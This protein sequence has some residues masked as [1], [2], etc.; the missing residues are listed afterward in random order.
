M[1]LVG[2]LWPVFFPVLGAII[3]L[4]HIRWKH[5]RGMNALETFLVWQLALSI[6]LNYLYSGIGHLVFPDQVAASIGWPPGSPFQREV[7]MWDFAIGIV[8]LLCLKF[9]STGFWIATVIA[10][11]IF[12]LG[13]G[14]GHVYELFVHGDV[15]VNNAGPVMFMDLLYPVFLGVLLFWYHKWKKEGQGGV[16]AFLSE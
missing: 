13:A 5:H 10:F 3:S 9:R 16:P 1:A 15:S 2:A 12:S 4:I 8:G 11:G 14:L 7:G 6:G